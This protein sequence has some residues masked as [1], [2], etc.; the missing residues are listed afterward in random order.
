MNDQ[1]LTR[2]THFIQKIYKQNLDPIFAT[3]GSHAADFAWMEKA[4][5][6]GLFLSDHS[7]LTD[8]ETQLV[9]LSAMLCQGYAGPTLWHLRGL[10]RLGRSAEEVEMVQ[11]AIEEVAVWAGRSIEGWVRV[12]DVKDEI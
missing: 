6:Y 3:W 1:I 5:I 10:R 4:V 7:I 12:G 2:G 11:R 9:T 8:V